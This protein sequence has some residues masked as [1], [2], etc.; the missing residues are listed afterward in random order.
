[1]WE[2][3]SSCTLIIILLSSAFPWPVPQGSRRNSA[4]SA[5]SL[6]ILWYVAAPGVPSS[7]SLIILW[8][9]V[10]LCMLGCKTHCAE[11][12]RRSYPTPDVPLRL[13]VSFEARLAGTVQSYKCTV[14]SCFQRRR[15]IL[16]QTSGE[17]MAVLTRSTQ[18]ALS[19]ALP[20]LSLLCHLLT[21]I[22]TISM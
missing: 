12:R 5:E 18:A 4:S 1:M 9:R 17:G 10:C 7:V 8:F 6:L 22:L 19:G 14:S 16:L 3:G 21:V 2:L 15:G 11:S 20:K 13:S